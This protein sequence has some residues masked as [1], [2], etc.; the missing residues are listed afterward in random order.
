MFVLVD[1]S[2][3]VCSWV[4]VGEPPRNVLSKVTD[5]CLLEHQALLKVALSARDESSR[6]AHEI[7]LRVVRP[8]LERG[9]WFEWGWG[10]G[11]VYR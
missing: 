1:C 2:G 7:P 10:V 3:A 9:S 11:R 4:R 6:V 5:S 8:V